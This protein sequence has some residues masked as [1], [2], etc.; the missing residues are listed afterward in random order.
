M[1]SIANIGMKN[2]GFSGAEVSSVVT[3]VRISLLT[4]VLLRE[5]TG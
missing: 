4:P 2:V 5:A 3:V 1:K